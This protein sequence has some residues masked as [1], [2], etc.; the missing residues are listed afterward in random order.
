MASMLPFSNISSSISLS[1]QRPLTNTKAVDV[2]GFL[3]LSRDKFAV[4]RSRDIRF[5]P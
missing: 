3:S 4:L 5:V 2:V 1:F